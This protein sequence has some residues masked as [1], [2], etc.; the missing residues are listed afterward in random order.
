MTYL[1][2]NRESMIQMGDTKA[3]KQSGQES[4]SLTILIAQSRTAG[5][6]M[7]K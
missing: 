2:D 6:H 7:K 3:D 4:T 1:G 5:I